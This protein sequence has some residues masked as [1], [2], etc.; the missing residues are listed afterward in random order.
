MS[1]SFLGKKKQSYFE[2]AQ[3]EQVDTMTFSF[4]LPDISRYEFICST[5][6]NDGKPR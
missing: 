6:K 4:E 1:Y 3:L 5:S 2:Y